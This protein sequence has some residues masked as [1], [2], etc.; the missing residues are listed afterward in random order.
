MNGFGRFT[1]WSASSD[2][3][4]ARAVANRGDDCLETV[5]TKDKAEAQALADKLNA[6]DRTVELRSFSGY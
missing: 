2:S 5:P 3:W 4:V 6:G 1:V